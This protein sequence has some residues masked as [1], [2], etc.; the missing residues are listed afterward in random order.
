MISNLVELLWPVM[1]LQVI[2]LVMIMVSIVI[3]IRKVEKSDM[4]VVGILLKVALTLMLLWVYGKMYK[5][6]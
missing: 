2:S 6:F 3:D 5:I 4:E 1:L